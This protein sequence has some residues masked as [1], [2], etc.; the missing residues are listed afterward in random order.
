M[1]TE[2]MHRYIRTW[3]D[4]LKAKTPETGGLTDPGDGKAARPFNTNHEQY[5]GIELFHPAHV[6]FTQ[7][8]SPIVQQ[9]TFRFH[10]FGCFGRGLI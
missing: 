3:M 7:D 6:L 2:Y 1:Y 4:S 8:L 9:Q 5:T 10:G